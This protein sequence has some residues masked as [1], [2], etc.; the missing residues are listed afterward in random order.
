MN[1]GKQFP[2]NGPGTGKRLAN[3]GLSLYIEG[4]FWDNVRSKMYP[5]TEV[6][7]FGKELNMKGYATSSGYMGFVNG[8]YMLFASEGEYL[9][10]MEYPEY[11]ED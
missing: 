3:A 1:K 7:V 2:G 4:D 6:I 11:R 10:Y 9:E 5:Y 8:R